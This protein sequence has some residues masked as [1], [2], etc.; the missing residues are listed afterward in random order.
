MDPT[1]PMDNPDVDRTPRGRVRL[2]MTEDRDKRRKYVRGVAGQPSD[3]GRLK[4]RTDTE[5]A[6]DASL[7]RAEV[8][9]AR[10]RQVLSTSVRL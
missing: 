3:R 10:R 5:A 4:N 1:Q 9:Q 2:R 6:I 7:D 8:R